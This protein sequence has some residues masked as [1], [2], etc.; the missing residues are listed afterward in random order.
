MTDTI[1]SLRA[2][3]LEASIALA[4]ECRGGEAGRCEDGARQLCSLLALF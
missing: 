4:G 2:E 3:A 1:E